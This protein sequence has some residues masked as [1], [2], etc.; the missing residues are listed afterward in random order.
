VWFLVSETLGSG[1]GEKPWGQ[2]TLGS[3]VVFGF[4]NLGVR[5]GFW[6]LAWGQVWK[7]LGSGVVFG[8]C[9][10]TLGSGVVFGFW[11]AWKT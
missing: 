5:C 1:V 11:R 6:F 7:T 2:E 8:F 3:G 10:K 9:K 4:R